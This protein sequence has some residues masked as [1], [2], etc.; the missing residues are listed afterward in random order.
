MKRRP[1]ALA[2]VT[3][4]I[5]A[6]VT[7]FAAGN[8]SRR[9]STPGA[10]PASASA[11][12]TPGGTGAAS[13]VWRLD[14]P[15]SGGPFTAR[16][17]PDARLVAVESTGSRFGLVIYEIQPPAPPS[18]VAYLREVLRLDRVSNPG[19][20]LPDSSGLL[21]YEPD[22]ASSATGTLSLV[23]TSGKRWS[24]AT[25]GLDVLAA[26][27]SPDARFASFWTNP[28][29]A[30]VV[31]LDGS[32]TYAIA[33]DD[34]QQFA[35]WDTE[36]NLL[37]R[38]KPA[39][40]LEARTLEARVVYTVPLPEELRE[41]G[42]YV[43]TFAQPRDMQVLSFDSGGCCQPSRH[44]MRMFFDR[45]V[46]E[47]PAGLE[48]LRLSNGDGPW[49]DREL[50]MRR[51]VDAELIAFDPRAGTMRT[52]GSKLPH[53]QPIW[54]ISGD[55]LAWGRHIVQ[56]STGRDQE[57]TV[58]PPPETII[59]LGS[60]R[61]VLWHDGTRELLDAAAWMAAPQSYTG[62][63]PMS[64]DQSSVPSGWVRVRDDDGG[65]TLARPRSWSSYEGSARG[66]VLASSGLLPSVMPGA[67]DVRV[68]IKLDIVGSRGPG[69]FLDGLAH[70]GGKV[71]ERR[72]VQ[73]SAGTT[74]FA[75]VYDNTQ[76]PSPTTSMNWALRS[77]FLP[78]RI[79]WIRA[80][81]LDSG[82]RAEVEAVVAT[83]E[84][85]APR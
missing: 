20:W 32:A 52:L 68:E 85:V 26:R 64:S 50:V 80:W 2:A 45:K 73:L 35:G 11:T 44:A 57:W 8:D 51:E 38:L 6:I 3:L 63:L 49:R 76:Y 39:N 4:T 55:F 62:E 31:A 23:T 81:P 33:S 47:F 12:P 18:D 56:L 74:E 21:V 30:L 25:T 82:R 36:G 29:G 59:A 65:F 61:F 60:G 16:L 17:S 15:K 79:V 46:H 5:V 72:T 28:R 10:E 54:G 13:P 77:P 42:A 78:D 40:V 67:G 43:P 27:F 1:L 71:I 75:I 37:F 19:Q 48:D 22:S 84:F 14:V 24:I 66:A 53:D 9:A 58:Q 41:L 34:T 69:D 83:L 70:H 7:M